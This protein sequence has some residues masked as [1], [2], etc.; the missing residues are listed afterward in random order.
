MGW[1]YIRKVDYN[2]K[3]CEKSNFWISYIYPRKVLLLNIFS[4]EPHGFYDAFEKIH[5]TITE[6][7]CDSSNITIKLLMEK[8]WVIPLK[9]ITII[10]LELYAVEIIC[11]FNADWQNCTIYKI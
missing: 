4:C 8:Y 5:E 2:G 6:K 1:P 11:T 10:R 7:T 3:F 9:P